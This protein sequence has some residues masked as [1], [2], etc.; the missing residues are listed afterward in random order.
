MSRS[1]YVDSLIVKKPGVSPPPT[2][3]P[4]I[5]TMMVP[6]LL[7]R[8]RPSHHLHP[9]PGIACYT[10]HPGDLFGAFCCPLCVH[11]PTNALAPH[12]LSAHGL[13]SA[14]LMTSAHLMT[15]H[16]SSSG[17]RRPA[18]PPTV[19]SS[20]IPPFSHHSD[21]SVKSPP[22]SQDP[23]PDSCEQT[24]HHPPTH[25]CRDRKRRQ[26]ET[27]VNGPSDDLP[28]CKRMRTAFTSTQ[29]LELERAFSSNMYL[30]RLRRI[31][32]ATCLSLSEKQV[33]IW[34]QNR[35]VKQKKEG[36]EVTCKCLRSCTSH[37]KQAGQGKQS[38]PADCEQ[39][40]RVTESSSPASRDSPD[41][42]QGRKLE[43]K[44]HRDP[45]LVP[46]CHGDVKGTLAG[47]TEV[48]KQMRNISPGG[49]QI[50]V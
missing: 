31:E 6:T 26:T 36:P 14:Q 12:S 32:I 11:V 2:S 35:R 13:T 38:Q 34:F 23:H 7:A 30:S 17:P 27:S 8:S 5:Q 22:L 19:T 44:G 33:K 49:N 37:V 15:S 47:V 4:H 24:P 10:R 29:L 20:Y 45:D 43:V 16:P 46:C 1:F 18:S 21:V 42:E 41:H 48:T 3:S 39:L 28:S 50:N 40:N 9:S 25:S